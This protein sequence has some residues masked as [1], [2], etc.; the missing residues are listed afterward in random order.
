MSAD[1]LGHKL[2]LDHCY[3]RLVCGSK[4]HLLNLRFHSL[5]EANTENPARDGPISSKLLLSQ[6]WRFTINHH[7]PY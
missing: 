2:K 6:G 4:G 5:P 7:K 1:L 3:K